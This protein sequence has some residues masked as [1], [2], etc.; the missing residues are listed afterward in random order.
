[1]AWILLMFFISY[2]LCSIFREKIEVIPRWFLMISVFILNLAD[3]HSTYIFIKKDGIQAEGNTFARWS[4]ENMGFA[5]AAG[6]KVVVFS[7]IILILGM[8]NCKVE[9]A[10]LLIIL[11]IT[12]A[13]N[14]FFVDF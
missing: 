7:M 13:R 8:C 2:F 10:S 12:V 4:I 3:I 1:M 11:S 5:Q 14:Y 9:L 6:L